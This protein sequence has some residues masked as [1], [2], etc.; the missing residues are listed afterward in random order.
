[1]EL[2][3]ADSAAGVLHLACTR[4]SRAIRP[5]FT[6]AFKSSLCGVST[7]GQADASAQQGSAGGGGGDAFIAEVA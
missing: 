4:R 5:L 2:V 1:M 3:S 6:L 7:L